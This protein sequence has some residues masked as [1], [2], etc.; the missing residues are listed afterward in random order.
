MRSEILDGAEPHLACALIIIDFYDK[1]NERFLDL[2]NPD[3]SPAGQ[4]LPVLVVHLAETKDEAE[5]R[6]D[7]WVANNYNISADLSGFTTNGERELQPADFRNLR[8]FSDPDWNASTVRT[9]S[10]A[11]AGP[12]IQEFLTDLNSRA[13]T[14]LVLCGN[15]P[16]HEIP[17]LAAGAVLDDGVD[18]IATQS[19]DAGETVIETPTEIDPGLDETSSQVIEDVI[20]ALQTEQDR[21][22]DATAAIP[23]EDPSELLYPYVQDFTYVT[24]TGTLTSAPLKQI[25][26]LECLLYAVSAELFVDPIPDCASEAFDQ[27]SARNA[28]LS[29]GDMGQILVIAGARYPRATM[30]EVRL[31]NG[32]G[33]GQCILDAEYTSEAGD[34]VKVALNPVAGSDPMLFRA[35]LIEPPQRSEDGLVRVTMTPED[36][37]LC[38]GDARSIEVESSEILSVPLV[39]GTPRNTAVLNVLISRE[40]DLSG[41][42]QLE[43]GQ[44]AQFVLSAA[45]AIRSAHA[46]LSA[47]E[48]DKVWALTAARVIA[49]DDRSRVLTLAEL[50]SSEMRDAVGAAFSGVTLESARDLAA[51]NPR[52]TADTVL[53]LLEQ[54]AQEAADTTEASTLYVNL[55]APVASRLA[56]GLQDPCSDPVFSAL[57]ADLAAMEAF[58]IRVSVYPVVRL[59]PG[60]T[61]DV[62]NLT[63]LDPDNLSPTLPSG[64]Y[65]CASQDSRLTV[66]PY[67]F[68]HWRDTVEFGARYGTSLAT[69]LANDLY[70]ANQREPN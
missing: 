28:R 38:G 47:L 35:E 37:A 2:L 62:S 52:I 13:D 55:I 16:C 24:G 27:L 41:G 45:N 25:D 50:T 51:Q 64:L 20:S 9:M 39:G 1:E 8:W 60:D 30:L 29:I 57:S 46:Q 10:V 33:G 3:S 65:A 61:V 12:D 53:S 49:L 14:I 26:R 66:K 40:A 15:G 21:E 31:P 6:F 36:A 44:R 54:A 63:P 59:Q 4:R 22:E 70:L 68:E 48:S 56:S 7:I 23:L 19:I 11:S 43:E 17:Q 58:D 32:I 67:Y 34:Q 5:D 18:E 42:L 69:A